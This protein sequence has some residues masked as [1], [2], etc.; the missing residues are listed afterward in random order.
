MI[1]IYNTHIIYIYII[2]IYIYIPGKVNLLEFLWIMKICSNSGFH[3]TFSLRYG[4]LRR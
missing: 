3:K 4:N 2:H 1:H